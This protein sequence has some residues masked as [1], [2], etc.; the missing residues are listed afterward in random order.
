MTLPL[1]SHRS[2]K[3]ARGWEREGRRVKMLSRNMAPFVHAPL[4]GPRSP[5]SAVRQAGG[6]VLICAGCAGRGRRSRQAFAISQ[7]LRIA[8]PISG[9]R[10][11]SSWCHQEASARSPLGNSSSGRWHSPLGKFCR[12]ERVYSA[13]LNRHTRYRPATTTRNTGQTGAVTAVAPLG[14]LTHRLS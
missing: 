12:L 3:D 11:I 9:S 8:S 5:F 13:V 7:H 14:G 1:L 6:A 10:L 4:P 2:T